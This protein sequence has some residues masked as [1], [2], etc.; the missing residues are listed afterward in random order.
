VVSQIWQ[1]TWG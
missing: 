1:F